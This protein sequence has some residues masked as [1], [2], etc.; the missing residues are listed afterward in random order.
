[1]AVRNPQPYTVLLPD[2]ENYSEGSWPRHGRL[3]DGLAAVLAE[4]A[5]Q[6]GMSR[7][8]WTRQPTGDGEL[9][10][11]PPTIPKHKIL[12]DLIYQLC[13]SLADFNQDKSD[14]YRLRVRLAVDAGDVHVQPDGNFSGDPPVTASRLSNAPELKRA[15]RTAPKDL[16]LIVSDRVHRDAVRYG[17]PGVN[18]AD[19]R[20][21]R[22]SEKTFD[23]D[24]WICVPGLA[25]PTG[26]EPL[27]GRH[28]ATSL[29]SSTSDGSPTSAVDR[30]GTGAA[31]AEQAEP[32]NRVGHL[33]NSG[34]ISFGGTA[35]QVNVHQ[36]PGRS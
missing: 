2:L 8:E 7:E 32:I 4:A 26:G 34:S 16:A 15:L 33:Q 12:S 14:R 31:T 23:E 20:Q 25:S 13:V 18:P 1:M 6:A 35:N 11:L 9:A 3:Q 21:I 24:A 10:L 29:D 36:R 19:Y 28:A 17:P 27:A 22:V 30:Q 5:D